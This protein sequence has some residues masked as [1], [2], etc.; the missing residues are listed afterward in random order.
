[1]PRCRSQISVPTSVLFRSES[2][3]GFFAELK[4]FIKSNW[5]AFQYEREQ[6]LCVLLGRCINVIGEKGKNV[7]VILGTLE[8]LNVEEL[9]PKSDCHRHV[10]R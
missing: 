4:A 2:N 6:E 8:P 7:K 5:Q 3:G 9:E 1:M 10:L